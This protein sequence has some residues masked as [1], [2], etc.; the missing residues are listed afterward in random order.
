LGLI[1][2][3]FHPTRRGILVSYF[4]YG[5][6]LAIAAAL[7]DDSYTIDEI[8]L[9]IANLRAGHRFSTSEEASGRLGQ[10][11]RATFREASFTNY[12]HRGVPIHYG[13]GA[14]E[15]ITKKNVNQ[16]M[17]EADFDE[18]R[19][20]DVER[21]RLEWRSLLKHIA[22]AP[23]LNWDRWLELKIAAKE[24]LDRLPEEVSFD[25]LPPLTSKQKQ[26]HRSFLSFDS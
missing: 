25:N 24:W 2:H 18:L 20:G 16:R 10:V 12:L 26:R 14:A 1:D 13:D 22:R 5:E 6:G 4:N 15:L 7:E 8:I 11:C 23:D 21:T 3:H 9:H 19:L 17:L